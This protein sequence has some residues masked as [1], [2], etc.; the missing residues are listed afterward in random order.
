MRRIEFRLQLAD[1]LV[2]A[3]GFRELATKKELVTTFG[4][5]RPDVRIGVDLLRQAGNFVV[6]LLAHL[7]A[8]TRTEWMLP[9]IV[10]SHQRCDDE[11]SK[12][13]QQHGHA[14]H[15]KTGSTSGHYFAP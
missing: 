4:N 9:R 12:G 10:R 2:V 8:V 3:N 7:F 1:S 6:P 15:E 13:G 11:K 14:A 5:Q